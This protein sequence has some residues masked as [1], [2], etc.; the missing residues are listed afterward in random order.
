MTG[1]EPVVETDLIGQEKAEAQAKKARASDEAA[2]QTGKASAC[3]RKRKRQSAGDEHHSCDRTQAKNQKV[4]NTPARL[5]DGGEDEQRYGG[6]TG[7]T[8]DYAD[9]QRS[10]GVK[11]T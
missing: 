11:Q 10:Q 4:E 8:V 7:E 5:A 6:R 3:V 2:T 1:E 9:Q